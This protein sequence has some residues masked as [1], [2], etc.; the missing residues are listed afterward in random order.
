MNRR[1]FISLSSG[2]AVLWPLAV[3][4]QQ[5]VKMLRVGAVSAQP[6]TTSFWQAFEQRMGE[7]GYQ[8]GKNFV[9]DFEYRQDL[10][11][12]EATYRTLI[13]R[14]ADII[15]ATGSEFTLRQARAVTGTLPIVMVAID[16]DPIARGF[17]T[18]LARPDGNVT[19]VF[20]QQ[21]ELTVKRL[22]LLKNAF[23]DLRAISVFWDQLS[24]DQWRAAQD[25]AKA[26]GLKLAG[27]EFREQPYDYDRA[28]LQ[29]APDYRRFVFV[30]TSPTFFRDRARIA[31]FAL[32]S[33][34]GSMFCF[35]EWV[36]A[37]GLLSYGPSISAMHRRAAEY[38]DRIARGA[39]PADLPIE[40]PT[41]FE[42]LINLRTGNALGLT[43]PPDL[44]VQAEEVIE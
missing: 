2:I 29:A 34:A 8:D 31:D 22:Q 37:G 18:S 39:K 5:A 1:E 42:L 30:L 10:K 28:F 27:I 26:L 16:Y 43:I 24:A 23:P 44:L 12:Y 38:V 36:D 4:A 13:E 11:T 15:V 32:Q 3:S 6:R 19:G 17:A 21:I 20:L 33:R 41:K 7:L 40:Q 25:G 9:F 14:K 35:R